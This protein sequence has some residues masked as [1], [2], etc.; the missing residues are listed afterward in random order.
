[1]LIIPKIFH[2]FTSIEDWISASS[3]LSRVQ[4]LSANTNYFSSLKR[5]KTAQRVMSYQFVNI[6]AERN[7]RNACLPLRIHYLNNILS[8]HLN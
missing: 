8:I 3:R 1:M 2:P 5:S 4:N 7:Y 6:V